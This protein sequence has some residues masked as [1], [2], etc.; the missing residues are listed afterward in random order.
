[1][2][3][4]SAPA[5]IA[6]LVLGAS[7]AAC[8]TAAVAPG[9]TAPARP[10]THAPLPTPVIVP[11]ATPPTTPASTPITGA[12]DGAPGGPELT[13]EVIDDETIMA[14][15]DDRE[16]K[17]WRLVVEG[18][19]GL[20]GERWEI[21]VETGD[22]GPV[23]SATEYHDGVVGEVLDL[24]GFWD[25]TA[26]A[27]GCHSKLPVCIDAD[28]FDVPE[29]DGRFA[30]KLVLPEASVP[31]TIRGGTATWDGEPF[32]LGPWDDTEAF[33]WGEG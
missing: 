2:V 10:V 5:L 14:T 24:T 17:A 30:A 31:L 3:P 29:G 23:I 26:A 33:P 21:L 20:A 32:I 6:A 11:A 8:G 27:G 1:M 12:V 19:G 18:V 22:I 9:A 15:L 13:I 25:G 7:L 28:G 4:R 16:A